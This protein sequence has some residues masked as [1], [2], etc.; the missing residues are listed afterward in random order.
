MLFETVESRS[1]TSCFIRRKIVTTN[2]TNL[3][4]LE[5]LH[6]SEKKN[7]YSLTSRDTNEFSC[8]LLVAHLKL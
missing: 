6:A 8:N 4:H 5:M 7:I 3:D 1:K 2:E